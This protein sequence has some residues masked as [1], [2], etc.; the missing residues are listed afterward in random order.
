MSSF[1]TLYI[2][3]IENVTKKSSLF[4]GKKVSQFEFF[5]TCTVLSIFSITL[6][7]AFDLEITGVLPRTSSGSKLVIDVYAG[8]T[9][10]ILKFV[11]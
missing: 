10:T 7:S 5:S 8:F 6:K 2:G 11:I 9:Y 3:I 4:F 1:S